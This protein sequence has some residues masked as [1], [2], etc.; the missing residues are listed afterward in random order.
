MVLAATAGTGL[1]AHGAVH[2][3]PPAK[4]ITLSNTAKEGL[5]ACGFG[6]LALVLRQLSRCCGCSSYGIRSPVT[7]QSFLYKREK[8]QAEHFADVFS[9]AVEAEAVVN[10]QRRNVKLV[11]TKFSLAPEGTSAIYDVVETT[12]VT[13]V[14][15]PQSGA[16][17]PRLSIAHWF[18]KPAA[19][20][21]APEGQVGSIPD[22]PQGFKGESMVNPREQ[23]RVVSDLSEVP[24]NLLALGL[25][26][27]LLE[28]GF[29][30]G[31]FAI[32]PWHGFYRNH[33]FYELLLKGKVRVRNMR[34]GAD[35]MCTVLSVVTH[36]SDPKKMHRLRG[37]G[38]DNVALEL[39]KDD[40]AALGVV[41][42][43]GKRRTNPFMHAFGYDVIMYGMDFT[44]N[45]VLAS[46][47]HMHP[48]KALNKIGLVSHTCNSTG[49]WSGA[50][51]WSQVNGRLLWSGMHLGNWGNTDY[52][53]AT[54]VSAY[55]HLRRIAGLVV[56]TPKL[57]AQTLDVLYSMRDQGGGAA[58]AMLDAYIQTRPNGEDAYEQDITKLAPSVVDQIP[59]TI[60]SG[61]SLSA[62]VSS[63]SSNR[64][65]QEAL[66]D[67]A[68][69]NLLEYAEG[70]DEEYSML[71]LTGDKQ[72]LRS[73]KDTYDWER[74][75]E[76][77]KETQMAAAGH[78]ARL[79]GGETASAEAASA[80]LQGFNTLGGG[81]ARMSW[82]DMFDD[83]SSDYEIL[84]A[85][86]NIP[87]EKLQR[88]NRILQTAAQT[89]PTA[90]APGL[91]SASVVAEVSPPDGDAL[92]L[93]ALEPPAIPKEEPMPS[94]AEIQQKISLQSL[95]VSHK[96]KE[97]EKAA[98]NQLGFSHASYASATSVISGESELE[99]LT[100]KPSD[101]EDLDYDPIGDFI[102]QK[103][104]LSQVAA[105]VGAS[106]SYRDLRHHPMMADFW[107]MV[108]TTAGRQD[109]DV[110]DYAY[111]KNGKLMARRVANISPQGK[112][113]TT[114]EPQ[115]FGDA[116]RDSLRALEQKM[117]DEELLSRG[118]KPRITE[119][120]P[121]L[122]SWDWAL[123]P[124][125]PR[126]IKDS[127]L[128][129]LRRL[130]AG[131]FSDIELVAKKV[132]EHWPAMLARYSRVDVTGCLDNLT[133]SLNYAFDSFDLTK[134][135]GWSARVVQGSKSVW[136]EGN[137]RARIE[138]WVRCRFLVHLAIG[139]G[140]MG[141]MS[142]YLLVK[143]GCK[144]PEELFIKPEAH[145]PRKRMARRW[146]LIWN[147]SLLDTL[148]LHAL[149]VRTNK[150]SL[151]DYEEGRMTHQVLGMGH[152]DE[153][154][155]KLG[156]IIDS[157]YQTGEVVTTSDASGWD[158]SVRRDGF[159]LDAYRR[160]HQAC[161]GDVDELEAFT[162]LLLCQAATL[163]AHVVAVGSDLVELLHF[164][165]LSSGI[166][167]TGE[168]NS[169]LR[170]FYAFCSGAVAT[171]ACSDDLVAAGE[172]NMDTLRAFGIVDP[173]VEIV[174]EG[175]PLDFTSHLFVKEGGKWKA[176]YNNLEK[177]FNGL[178]LRNYR[179]DGTMKTPDAEVAAGHRFALRHNEYASWFYARLY[180]A[181]GFFLPE[182]S[183]YAVATY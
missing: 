157:L 30:D 114:N 53:V 57:S 84:K 7:C 88:L 172:L 111:D 70:G 29:R 103:K 99:E 52:N 163:S 77:S 34:T 61:E 115:R 132:E 119:P 125:G 117:R 86:S 183:P 60:F 174:E 126:A 131:G 25:E 51:L 81:R 91:D 181:F 143:S 154:V 156:A 76:G 152:H 45:Q 140:L 64:S 85:V 39:H 159:Y 98:R 80:H 123:P 95:S 139:P 151:Q 146:R 27:Q 162:Q 72:G 4:V 135:T 36:L 37:F 177:L 121:P 112:G 153:G 14:A 165:I 182:A 176:V 100:T 134:S 147:P 89:T 164:G 167:S 47:G 12:R 150:Q 18:K 10:G 49:G 93:R 149:H 141:R 101:S 145:A 136:K 104:T 22:A 73:Y 28:L 65:L 96:T 169:F 138:E 94:L 32:T 15:A 118:R 109:V 107:K 179:P 56:K 48:D 9:T 130:E 6:G 11:L 127:L 8:T 78:A 129:Q 24:G 17:L 20:T 128:T 90:A 74:L 41:S 67:S 5:A 87:T 102:G 26:D 137:N 133:S 82:A 44:T 161:S 120:L 79:H 105:D 97:S 55:G 35:R 158:F 173:E 16:S 54:T 40:W 3:A 19:I 43:T 83:E 38:L 113:A 168:I 142:P 92:G 170:T 63:S 59:L 108:D 13:S 110:E 2:T 148:L 160:I 71:A 175:K 166:L 106:I 62:D 23:I 144:D 178:L 69:A 58:Q 124:T 122:L 171:M 21:S 33:D 155:E 66:E 42:L 46:C 116:M 75:H 31:N 50:V 68:Y 1:L 180:D